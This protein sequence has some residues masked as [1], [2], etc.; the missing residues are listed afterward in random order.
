MRFGATGGFMASVTQTPT[1]WTLSDPTNPNS[2][3]AGLGTRITSTTWLQYG[4][5]EA[6]LLSAPVV[7]IVTAF[8]SFA[9]NRDEI[10]W[11]NT[12]STPDSFTPN[13]FGEGVP[14]QLAGSN[15]HPL[16][17]G[18]DPAAEYVTLTVQWSETQLVWLINGQAVTTITKASTCDSSGNNCVYPSTPSKIQFALWDGGAGADGTRAWAG[19]YIPWGN[20]AA[21]GFNA[22][23]EYISIQ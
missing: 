7:G 11:E 3:P 13:Y 18:Y 12:R 16:S 20:D 4:V 17:I 22:T 10:D 9:E 6:R 15:Y 1:G 23:I 19:G 14:G 2:F 5:F 8:I 21:T